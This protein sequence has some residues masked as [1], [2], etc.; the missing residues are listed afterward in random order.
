MSAY[1]R[2]LFASTTSPRAVLFGVTND[3]HHTAAE[4]DG[5]RYDA[6]TLIAEVKD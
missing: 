6:E 3:C 4:N 5:R 1:S 2:P